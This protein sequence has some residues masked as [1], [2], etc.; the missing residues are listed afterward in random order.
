MFLGL[1]PSI[2]GLVTIV[3]NGV[4]FLQ[5]NNYL[6]IRGNCSEYE[7]YKNNNYDDDSGEEDDG[8]SGEEDTKLKEDVCFQKDVLFGVFT[9]IFFFLP[10]F[11]IYLAFISPKFQTQNILLKL[12]LCLVCVL[13]FPVLFILIKIC[14]LFNHGQNIKI[15][16]LKFVFSKCLLDSSLQLCFQVFA[17]MSRA[18]RIPSLIQAVA[19]VTAVMAVTK[20]ITE[21]FLITRTELSYLSGKTFK[22]K[23]ILMAKF[24]PLFFLSTVFKCF[25][26]SIIISIL[27]LHAIWLYCSFLLLFLLIE[28]F[29]SR[30]HQAEAGNLSFV[31]YFVIYHLF[32]GSMLEEIITTLL[33]MS[34]TGNHFFYNTFFFCLR[35]WRCGGPRPTRLCS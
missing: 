18:D 14:C 15:L 24:C 31:K 17:M 23:I 8:N 3:I 9:M 29:I 4:K 25:S 33:S 34:T 35:C 6:I 30:K 19:A 16:S 28:Y 27:G 10:G 13:V 5:G 1:I 12:C 22:Q 7:N 26:I 11:K 2:V 20:T 32:N 21:H